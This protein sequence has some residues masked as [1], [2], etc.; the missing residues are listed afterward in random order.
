MKEVLAI[1]KLA[2]WWI[3]KSYIK[4]S[5]TFSWVV[6]A[7]IPFSIFPLSVTKKWTKPRFYTPTAL[8][9]L[10]FIHIDIK[11]FF[12][13]NFNFRFDVIFTDKFSRTLTSSY[14]Q[15]EELKDGLVSEK[16]KKTIMYDMIY[17]ASFTLSRSSSLKMQRKSPVS[18]HLCLRKKT[19]SVKLHD[20]RD[21][22]VFEKHSFHN[23]FRP[24]ENEKPVFTNFSC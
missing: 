1:S 10:W 3:F 12:R 8:K 11:Y 19:L 5:C 15:L 9:F 13:S 6:F 20:F 24:H 7:L 22:I 2:S 23:L 16:K 14:A 21:A 17:E 18:S 4:Y